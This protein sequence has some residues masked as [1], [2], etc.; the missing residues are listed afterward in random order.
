MG[1]ARKV[2]YLLATCLCAFILA[3]LFPEQIDRRDYTGAVAAYTEN[4]TQENEAALRNQ[5]QVNERIH[6]RDSAIL[7][8]GLAG[9]G[10]GI[11]RGHRFVIRLS[12]SN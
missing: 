1:A 8:L 12:T 2:S 6:L 7:G 4:P 11:W 3:Y 5:R 10:C 9:L